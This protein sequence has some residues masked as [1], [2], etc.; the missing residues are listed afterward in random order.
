MKSHISIDYIEAMGWSDTDLNDYR[1][2]FCAKGRERIFEL[3]FF[4]NTLWTN[5]YFLPFRIFYSQASQNF[6][7]YMRFN[8][9]QSSTQYIRNGAGF[10]DAVYLFQ[11][12]KNGEKCGSQLVKFV[13]LRIKF[14]SWRS[15]YVSVRT[16]YG[17]YQVINTWKPQI[18]SEPDLQ[19]ERLTQTTFSRCVH[20]LSYTYRLTSETSYSLC[21]K[22][23]TSE[24]WTN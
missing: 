7:T 11:G 2:L 18:P 23:L 22:L 12:L 20:K 16:N 9:R 14:V 1:L 4:T 17:S 10:T 21:W 15:K 6:G 8:F 19:D 5:A 24:F 13:F 3:Q